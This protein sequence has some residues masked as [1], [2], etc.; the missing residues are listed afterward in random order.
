VFQ[1]YVPEEADRRPVELI[2]GGLGEE[3]VVAQ[4]LE[5]HQHVDE[6]LRC[7]SHVLEKMGI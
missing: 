3:L 5:H 2:L 6:A 4:R 7:S 1:D